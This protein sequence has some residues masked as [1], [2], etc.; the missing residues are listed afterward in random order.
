MHYQ[1]T[2]LTENMRFY[3]LKQYH[4]KIAVADTFLNQKIAL[5]SLKYNIRN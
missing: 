4:L 1:K 3:L 5:Y 2:E